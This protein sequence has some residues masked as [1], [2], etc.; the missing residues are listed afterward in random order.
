[1]KSSTFLRL[2]LAALTAAFF[3]YA[4]A[5]DMILAPSDSGDAQQTSKKEKFNDPVPKIAVIT[6]M[7]YEGASAAY[8]DASDKF[9]SELKAR[10]AI[11]ADRNELS[12]LIEAGLEKIKEGKFV[13]SFSSASADYVLLID[14]SVKMTDKNVNEQK[15]NLYVS[16]YTAYVFNVDT[17]DKVN[18]H[19]R[20]AKELGDSPKIKFTELIDKYF[21]ET[22]N[23]AAGT[24]NSHRTRE[25][26][27]KLTVTGVEDADH[28]N[29]LLENL[30]NN[31]RVAEVRA[32]KLAKGK[33]TTS[34]FDII[35]KGI[36]AG[37]L[38]KILNGQGYGLTTEK[39]EKGS[40]WARYD[41]QKGFAIKIYV[42]LFDNLTKNA[43][44]DRYVDTMPAKFEA[45]LEK[46]DFIWIKRF[47]DGR[48]DFPK[49][50]NLK[51]VMTAASDETGN[52]F[53]LACELKIGAKDKKELAECKLYF[54]ATGQAVH[55]FALEGQFM[56]A[57][58]FAGQLSAQTA[59]IMT[60]VKK[61]CASK[62]SKRFLKEMSLYEK[63]LQPKK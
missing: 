55:S 45:E 41:A 21:K 44:N 15:Q 7:T 18:S 24:I 25:F 26:T 48:L 8:H 51:K 10:G 58:S 20:A 50:T 43:D 19:M 12:G 40:V 28:N 38:S 29:D 59:A 57:D 13:D 42:S 11:A 63:N 32:V 6:Y 3:N 22:A 56:D 14:G 16:E 23:W 52:P 34:E 30:A 31:P 61:K 17:G 1:M 60:A 9:A 39:I 54:A 36:S 37:A 53:L 46:I 33:D 4:D 5:K 2:A 27:V 35:V 62:F 49:G 47:K